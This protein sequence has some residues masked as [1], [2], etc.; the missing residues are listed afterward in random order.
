MAPSR[1]PVEPMTF[2]D[3][4]SNGVRSLGR[5]NVVSE[6]VTIAC[7]HAASVARFGLIRQA[8]T[9]APLHPRAGVPV[10]LP[11]STASTH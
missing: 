10:R 5:G 11:L 2:G 8:Q 4:L 6:A 9:P 7:D 1:E 3:M